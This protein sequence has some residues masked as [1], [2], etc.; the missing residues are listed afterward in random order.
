MHEGGRVGGRWKVGVGVHLLGRVDH[1]G[2]H[3]GAKLGLLGLEAPQ[4]AQLGL[5]LKHDR[6]EAMRL[7]PAV[8]EINKV[9]K[10][11]HLI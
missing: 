5:S 9:F 6:F 11:D 3:D 8:A 4:T 1:R 10:Y 2:L 7:G